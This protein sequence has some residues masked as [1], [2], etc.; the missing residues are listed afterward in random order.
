MN[1]QIIERGRIAKVI[2]ENSEFKKLLEEIKMDLF[3]QFA[4][5]GV[6]ED[7]KKEE[8][9]KTM[10]GFNLLIKKINTYVSVANLELSKSTQQGE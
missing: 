10:A 2:A 5:T 8:M 9:H 4:Q 6:M 3:Y 7:E 1:E